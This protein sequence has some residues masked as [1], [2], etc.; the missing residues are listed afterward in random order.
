LPKSFTLGYCLEAKREK[1][2]HKTFV[3]KK[4]TVLN[5]NKKAP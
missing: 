4:N 1:D 2:I 5:E 3:V